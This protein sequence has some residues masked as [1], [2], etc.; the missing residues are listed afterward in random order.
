M[1]KQNL[2]FAIL[3][4]AL[5]SCETKTQETEGMAHEDH[6][7]MHMD[8]KS[9]TSAT[10]SVR[11][12]KDEMNQIIQAYLDLKDRLVET[13]GE[14]AKDAAAKLLSTLESADTQSKESL[15]AE[16]KKIAES[17]DPEVQRAAFDLVSQQMYVL[18]KDATLAE[19]TLYKQYCPMAK[20]NEGAFWLS[21]SDEIR[22]PYFGDR[23][24]KCGRVDEEISKL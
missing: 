2:I 23:M 9:S 19:G 15:K 3:F 16:V 21:A 14:Q 13:D 10:A 5:M 4:G 1:K 6:Q 18:A 24:L 11:F 22:N 12:E 20:N 8:A 17:T 7:E